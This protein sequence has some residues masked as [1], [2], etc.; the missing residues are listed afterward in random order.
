MGVDG[1]TT[2]LGILDMR[3]RIPSCIARKVG[4]GLPKGITY[5]GHCE[6]S[7]G[8]PEAG[9]RV[10]CPSAGAETLTYVNGG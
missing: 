5:L 2:P 6:R 4:L 8:Y 3:H 10:G 7:G 9:L 1:A